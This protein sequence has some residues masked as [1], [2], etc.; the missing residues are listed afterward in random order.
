MTLQQIFTSVCP[1]LMKYIPK[2]SNDFKILFRVPQ[3]TTT[4]TTKTHLSSANN[5]Q[6][7]FGL[8]NPLKPVSLFI[9]F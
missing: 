9:Y 3:E 1:F 7:E 4:T 8:N 6:V 5:L 2:L